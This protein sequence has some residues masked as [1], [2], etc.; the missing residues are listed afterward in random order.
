ML[1]RNVA[2]VLGVYASFEIFVERRV[3]GLAGK[4]ASAVR[5]RRRRLEERRWR[6]RE[7]YLRR[8]GEYDFGW[9]SSSCGRPVDRRLSLR[10]KEDEGYEL[11]YH[12]VEPPATLLGRARVFEHV[13]STHPSLREAWATAERLARR[14]MRKRG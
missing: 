8:G 7:E 10:Y 3:A 4:T 12:I 9:F 2:L 1:F 14:L 6:E 5:A 13:V 11:Y